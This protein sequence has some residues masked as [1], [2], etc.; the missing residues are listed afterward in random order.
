[1]SDTSTPE[2]LST[3]RKS[4]RAHANASSDQEKR[5]DAARR[6]HLI[7][8]GKGGIGKTYVASLL[9]QYHLEA[10]RPVVCYDTDPVN[11]SLSAI[12]ALAAK[13]VK[14]F[15]G[16]QIAVPELDKLVSDFLSATG[17]VIVDNGAASFVPMSQYL[18]ENSI[19]EILTEHGVQ[20]V[21][22]AVITGGG[23]IMD[24]LRGLLS[25]FDSYPPTVRVVIWIN[26]FFGPVV[27]DGLELE[28]M[29]IYREH[30]DRIIGIVRL[31]RLNP[32]SFGTN[33]LD[34]IDRKLT[35]AEALTSPDFTIVPRQ[36]LVM[37]RRAIFD[38]MAEVV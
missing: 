1:M 37:V 18:I 33:L 20:M 34:M 26:E 3:I 31:E 29:P 13:P 19:S 14:L 23:M 38:Q 4:N 25:I 28:H 6:V 8:Q 17:D 27:A 16:D 5:A 12:P 2:P 10:G 15:N 21:I 22:H 32:V 36:R 11:S 30:R 24:T 9:A 35:F 7:L